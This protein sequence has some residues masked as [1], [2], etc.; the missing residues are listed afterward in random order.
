MHE[1][2]EAEPSTVF[3]CESEARATAAI[4]GERIGASIALGAAVALLA[5]ALFQMAA[6]SGMSLPQMEPGGIPLF[7]RWCMAGSMGL[8]AAITSCPA[9]GDQDVSRLARW[10]ATAACAAT[11]VV[12][13]LAP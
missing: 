13:V 8:L 2:T 3:A 7:A 1:V 9:S 10:A 5:Y 12:V 6:A 4:T 11:A